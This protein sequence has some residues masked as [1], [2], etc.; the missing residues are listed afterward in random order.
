MGE[1]LGVLGQRASARR[2]GPQVVEELLLVVGL[3]GEE[4]VA[5]RE[6]LVRRV[7]GVVGAHSGVLGESR[8]GRSS[9]GL[10]WTSSRPSLRRR[11]PISI[12]VLTVPSVVLVR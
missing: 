7:A 2:A 10:L 5:G 1:R 6:L 11:I 9:V 3:E 4:G 12:R 8:G